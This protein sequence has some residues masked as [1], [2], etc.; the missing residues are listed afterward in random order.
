MFSMFLFFSLFSRS[1]WIC[2]FYFLQISFQKK[3]F[4]SGCFFFCFC[5]F[6]FVF[7]CFSLL[8]SC[9]VSSLSRT[10]FSKTWKYLFSAFLCVTNL[11]FF[12]QFFL[13]ENFFRI[14][15]PLFVFVTW[16]FETLLIVFSFC[17]LLKKS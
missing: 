17:L 13:G 1:V 9:C 16:V 3:S 4:V 2:F 8:F 7:F 11:F 10:F 15:F 6:F 12:C 14:M 5:F